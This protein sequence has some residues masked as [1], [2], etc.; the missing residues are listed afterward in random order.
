MVLNKK[1]IIENKLETKLLSGF[2]AQ[3]PYMKYIQ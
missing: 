2:L 3:T 1:N